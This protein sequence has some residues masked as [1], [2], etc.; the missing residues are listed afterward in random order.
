MLELDLILGDYA[1]KHYAQASPQT[2]QAFQDLLAC[3]DQ[4]L[5]DWLVSHVLAPKA[6]QEIIHQIARTRVL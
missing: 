4:E 5:F 2:Q 1:Q 3:Q 6:H